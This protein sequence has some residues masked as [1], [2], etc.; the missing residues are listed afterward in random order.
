KA[1]GSPSEIV[2]EITSDSES[3]CD[4]HEP[5]PPLP[6]LIGAEHTSTSNSLISLADLTLTMTVPKKTKQTSDIVSPVNVIKKKT[7]TKAPS[8]AESC[9]DKKADS[10]TE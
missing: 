5:L 3:E 6:K 2:L 10:S 1:D 9:S 4:T 8:K 7:K